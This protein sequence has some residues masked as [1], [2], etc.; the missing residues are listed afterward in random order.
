[1][2]DGP[3]NSFKVR[4]RIN[5]LLVNEGNMAVMQPQAMPPARE[6]SM[7]RRIARGTIA[8]VTAAIAGLASVVIVGMIS[9]GAVVGLRGVIIAAVVGVVV[10]GVLLGFGDWTV[11]CL[12]GGLGAAVAGFFAVTT[13]E[14]TPPGSV[15]WAVQGGLYGAG[16][17]VL[18][19]AIAGVVVAVIVLLIHPDRDAPAYNKPA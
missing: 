3:E 1:L 13:A 11:R 6:S 4:T 5:S 19:A 8:A 14:Q 18:V 9:W 12:A 10:G 17:G 7:F 15:E 2:G 16:F